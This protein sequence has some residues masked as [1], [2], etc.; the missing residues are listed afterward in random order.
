MF[1]NLCLVECCIWVNHRIVF[2]VCMCTYIYMCEIY[3][4]TVCFEMQQ[5][6]KIHTFG[7]TLKTKKRK[8]ATEENKNRNKN[9]KIKTNQKKMSQG[10]EREKNSCISLFFSH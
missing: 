4:V 7:Q 8:M 10:N 2:T 6:S 3:G 1:S 5:N 9:E